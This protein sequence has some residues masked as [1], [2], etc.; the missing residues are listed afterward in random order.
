MDNSIEKREREGF[1]VEAWDQ[2]ALTIGTAVIGLA[3]VE[4]PF[5]FKFE[6]FKE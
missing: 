6:E 4:S 3:D 5:L 1:A 2:T